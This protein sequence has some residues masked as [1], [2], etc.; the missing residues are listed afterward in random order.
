MSCSVLVSKDQPKAT[1]QV[2]ESPDWDIL[3]GTD[4]FEDI[5]LRGEGFRRYLRARRV[6]GCHYATT[7][8]GGPTAA[9]NASRYSRINAIH[10]PQ[11]S[12]FYIYQSIPFFT[13]CTTI[14]ES[15][16]VKRAAVRKH[17]GKH[18]RQ[19]IQSTTYEEKGKDRA[20][21]GEGKHGGQN[22]Q[23]EAFRTITKR[24]IKR[25]G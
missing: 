15:G 4:H 23:N 10:V 11:A 20:K 21:F 13:F 24:R 3:I 7:G 18:S 19:D 22:I 9:R 2:L 17:Q 1:Y 25:S 12:H 14:N 8:P 5:H 6:Y 16:G